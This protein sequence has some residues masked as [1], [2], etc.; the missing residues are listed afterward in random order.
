MASRADFFLI[1]VCFVIL[2]EKGQA[3]AWEAL[4]VRSGGFRR[5]QTETFETSW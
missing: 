3:K 5:L 2:Y 1:L 4:H